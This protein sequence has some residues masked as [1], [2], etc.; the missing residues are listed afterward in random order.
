MAEAAAAGPAPKLVDELG[1]LLFQSYFLALLCEEAGAGDLAEVVDGD[2]R[3]ADPPP[4]A[5]VRRRGRRRRPA[6]CAA[7]GSRSSAT[8]EGREG[9]FHDVPGVLPALLYARK[10]QRRASAVGFDWHAWDGAWSDLVDELG[11]LR[12]ALD[13]GAGGARRAR[14]GRPRRARGRRPPVRGGQRRPAG[15]RR[16]RAGAAG[17]RRAASATASSARQLWPDRRRELGRARSGCPGRLVPAGEAARRSGS[18]GTASRR[19]PSE[20]RARGPARVRP[21]GA[22]CRP[23]LPLGVEQPDGPITVLAAAGRLTIANSGPGWACWTGR[24]RLRRPP[25]QEVNGRRIYRRG[26][27]ATPGVTAFWRGSAPPT[28]SPCA[29][30]E[31]ADRLVTLELYYCD[32]ATPFGDERHGGEPAGADARG[33]LHPGAAGGEAGGGR[34]AVQAAGRAAPGDH[35]R[36]RSPAATWTTRR[37]SSS[38]CSD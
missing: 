17:G 21:A 35:L 32:P 8:D 4:P 27:P 31:H 20:P 12:E 18:S 1:D 28:T 15:Q 29:S 36:G 24:V 19:R 11:E 6:R 38:T 26:D 16:S 23:R 25:P 34:G 22:R 13:A 37:H 5:R 7:T 2:H 30:F 9:I 14:A 33:G 3:Q 10:V